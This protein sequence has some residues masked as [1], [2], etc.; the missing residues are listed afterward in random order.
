[1]FQMLVICDWLPFTEKLPDG[2]F[3][4]WFLFVISARRTLMLTYVAHARSVVHDT[5]RSISSFFLFFS[6]EPL[7][8]LFFPLWLVQAAIS[9]RTPPRGG[10]PSKARIVWEAT[11][12]CLRLLGL[13]QN[14]VLCRENL[15]VA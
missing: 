7:M 14:Q 10:N 8:L 6:P 1:M 2:L 12:H 3:Y 4:L 9:F 15:W 13:T 5:R 11:R